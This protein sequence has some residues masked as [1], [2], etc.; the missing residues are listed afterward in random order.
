MDKKYK[1]VLIFGC[2]FGNVWLKK[3]EYDVDNFYDVLD[4]D[5]LE[6]YIGYVNS[7]DREY[8]K[9][10]VEELLK[11]N[12]ENWYSEGEEVDE[13]GDDSNLWL[14]IKVD[15]FDVNK[16]FREN[17]FGYDDVEDVY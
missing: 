12:N 1:K 14:G 15:D 2:S 7:K 16:W 13:G 4:E 3:E 9:E 11:S 17:W 8:N 10:E 5:G 6:Y